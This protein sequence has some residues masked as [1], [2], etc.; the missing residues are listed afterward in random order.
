[1]RGGVS[2]PSSA[3]S[4]TEMVASRS[5]GSSSEATFAQRALA[6][7]EDLAGP[8][9]RPCRGQHFQAARDARNDIALA[10][11]DG[12]AHAAAAL[13]PPRVAHVRAQVARHELDDAVL[14]AAAVRVRERQVVGIG[15]DRKRLRGG[16]RDGE[17]RR[18]RRGFKA[19]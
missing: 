17:G 4:C 16:G 15:A 19:A 18:E 13:R 1:M 7:D 10:R 2:V 14:E 3:I 6:R 11:T 8:V 5:A 9:V 12:A